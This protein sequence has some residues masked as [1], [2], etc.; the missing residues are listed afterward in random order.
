MVGGNDSDE[1]LVAKNIAV[2][3]ND[4]TGREFS[5]ERK[6]IRNFSYLNCIRY[7]RF[8]FNPLFYPFDYYKR[9]G[10]LLCRNCFYSIAL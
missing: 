6:E 2:K 4:R 9:L 8:G 5:Y 10:K 7:D 3:R 1:S